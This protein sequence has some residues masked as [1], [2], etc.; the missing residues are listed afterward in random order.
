MK[1]LLASAILSMLSFGA[2]AQVNGDTLH[3]WCVEEDPACA[4]FI[5]GFIE[6]H[7]SAD[8][9]SA[10]GYSALCIPSG[11]TIEQAVE[12]AKQYLASSAEDRHRNSG[13]LLMRAFLTAWP[14]RETT[15]RIGFD[16]KAGR[17]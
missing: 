4:A 10:R 5:Q 1:R 14:M 3:R 12:I 2:S 6:G 17:N 11:T 7:A 8:S 9:Y 16:E 13:D 15:C